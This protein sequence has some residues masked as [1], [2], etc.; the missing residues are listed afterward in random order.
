MGIQPGD[1]GTKRLTRISTSAGRLGPSASVRVPISIPPEL[2]LGA[3]QHEIASAYFFETYGWAPFWQHTM[4][5]AA[6][7]DAPAVNKACLQAIVYGYA[8]MKRGDTALC[9]RAGRLYGQVL[10]EVKSLIG[11]SDKS[12]LARLT[13][14]LMLLDMYEF[15]VDKKVSER[16]SHH[17][18]IESILQHCG[19]EFFQ[20]PGLLQMFRSCRAL[21]LCHNVYRR[22]RSFLQDESWKTIPWEHEPKSFEDRLMDLFLDLPGIAQDL[23]RDDANLDGCLARLAAVSSALRAWRRD[24]DGAHNGSVRR[25]WLAAGVPPGLEFDSPPLALDILYYNAAVVYLMQ[26]EAAAAQMMSTAPPRGSHQQQQ[27]QEKQRQQSSEAAAE[28]L[29][30]LACIVRSLPTIR[31]RKTVV[32]PAPIGILYSML[33]NQNQMHALVQLIEGEFEDAKSI[34]GFYYAF[35]LEVLFGAASRFAPGTE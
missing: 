18:G 16:L 9:D 7:D 10:H 26:M 22:T 4:L 33:Q 25:V 5:A 35:P 21:L 2:D 19:P 14:T 17:L 34:F 1:N 6:T 32:T 8:G 12:E 29:V 31:G 23:A 30:A 24:W 28:A 13:V 3:F 27:Q 20:G 11:A 15:I